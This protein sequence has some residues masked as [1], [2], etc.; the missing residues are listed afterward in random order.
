M[1]K[2]LFMLLM[3]AVTASLMAGGTKEHA[4]DSGTAE[5]AEAHGNPVK[6]TVTLSAVSTDTHAKA[7]MEL[8]DYVEKSSGGNI[9]VDVYTDSAIF[10]QAEEVSAVAMGDADITLTSPS[11]LASGS[12]WE[13]MFTAGYLFKNYDHMTAVLNGDIGKKAFR[14]IADEQ[15]LLPLGAWYLGSRVVSLKDDIEVKTPEDMAGITLRMPNSEAYMFL[16][17][18]L[19]ANVT[20]ID[21]SELYLALQTGVV[22]GQDNPLPTD[23]NARFYE[24]QSCIILTK[25][26]M[27]SVWPAINRDTWNSMT[28]AQQKI[29]MEGVE[30][31]RRYCD[32]TNIAMEAELVSFFEEEGLHIY[33]PDVDA[34]QAYALECYLNSPISDSWDMDL[35]KEIVDMAANY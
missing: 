30:A 26:L 13:S 34:F 23:K 22:D 4:E 5:A 15:G 18:A 21:F 17:T 28:E 10:T 9:I 29:L 25:H 27:D 33:Y 14:T 35:Y 16:G 7:M 32:D 8:K 1:K 24:V 19:G 2:I 20:P 12:P 31:G 6:L 3:L 11:W